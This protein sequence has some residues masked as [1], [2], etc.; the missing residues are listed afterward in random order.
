MYLLQGM[1]GVGEGIEPLVVGIELL[2]LYDL[3]PLPGDKQQ[4]AEG[5]AY[6]LAV[7]LGMVALSQDHLVFGCHHLF[8]LLD[9]ELVSLH[10]LNNC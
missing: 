10:S 3:L 8:H 6:Y 2:V 5:L 7:V 9:L 1:I 4:M